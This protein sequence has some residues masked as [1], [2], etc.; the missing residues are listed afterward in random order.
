MRDTTLSGQTIQFVT[1]S[2]PQTIGRARIIGRSSACPA[3]FV[4]STP[5]A[6]YDAQ[7]VSGALEEGL[8]ALA[9]ASVTAPLTLN[10]SLFSTDLDGDGQMDTFH[11]CTS[12]EGIH[13]TLWNGAPASGRREWH[14]YVYV[15]YDLDPTCT[16]AES[17]PDAR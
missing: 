17:R 15:G 4:D 2:T 3:L 1:A 11:W 8:P 13:L 6:F 9:L 5:S 16:E 12:A 14:R 7:V 10:D